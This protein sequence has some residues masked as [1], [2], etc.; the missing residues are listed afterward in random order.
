MEPTSETQ[1]QKLEHLLQK[2]LRELPPRRAPASL[3]Q[4]VLA[5]LGRRA[6]LPWWRKS[7]AHWPLL[8]RCAFLLSSAVIA[9]AV[10]MSTV[11]IMLGF[12][13]SSAAAA[14]AT[15]VV[16]LLSF[17]D[18]ASSWVEFAGAVLSSV[19]RFW[20]YAGVVCLTAMYA[21]LFGV[22]AFV[23][24]LFHGNRHTF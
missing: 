24:R 2:T 23:Y 14:V 22:G 19:P 1:E 18:L 16:W 7:Y 12:E 9:K 17:A 11:W 6:A 3:E 13:S 20:I 4:R 15:P 21:T 10:I 5:E 8:A